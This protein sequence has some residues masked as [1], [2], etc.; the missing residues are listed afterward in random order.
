ML[1]SKIL[2]IIG[3]LVAMVGAALLAFDTFHASRGIR[4]AMQYKGY[5]KN[6]E[7][8][9]RIT[10]TSYL[11]P[12]YTEEE[13]EAAKAEASRVKDESINRLRNQVTSDDLKHRSVVE[14]L[15]GYGFIMVAIG[16][17]MQAIS[18]TIGQG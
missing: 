5:E 15:A 8:I 4:R 16:S 3:P 7:D 9:Y 1:L 2:G 13:V 18:V 11:S 17:L 12:P 14:V 6:H 10:I